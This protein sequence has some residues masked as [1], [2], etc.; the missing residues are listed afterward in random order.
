M[1]IDIVIREGALLNNIHLE[2]LLA[3]SSNEL[4]TASVDALMCK[5]MGVAKQADWPIAAVS[6]IGQSQTLGS[7]VPDQDYWLMAHPVHLVLQRDYFSL[8]PLALTVVS[9]AELQA[10]IALL[11]QHF[12]RDGLQFIT[13]SSAKDGINGFYLKLSENPEI[14][15]TLP[16]LAAGRDIRQH[17]PQGKGMAK[18]HG[19]LNE[20]QMLLHDHAINQLREQNSLVPINSIWLSG[21]GFYQAPEQSIKKTIFAKSALLR[22]LAL[23]NGLEAMAIPESAGQ[24][25]SKEADILLEINE[26]LDIQNFDFNS[27]MKALRLG[28]LKKINLYIEHQGQVLQANIKRIDTLKF[29]RKIKPINSYFKESEF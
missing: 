27:L 19:I 10:L 13:S 21:G 24:L 18:W 4:V 2:R 9:E 5:L 25:L 7:Q 17:M 8:Y 11:N 14:S 22:G 1:L 16:E 28:N 20:I 26:A 29:W 6:L 23:M 15:T 3:V 12:I